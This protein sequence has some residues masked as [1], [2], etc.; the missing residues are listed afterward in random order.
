MAMRREYGETSDE[1]ARREEMQGEKDIPVHVPNIYIGYREP[2][3]YRDPD[4]LHW[5]D[6][7]TCPCEHCHEKR[8]LTGCK[9]IT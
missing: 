3:G 4:N 5:H 8:K 1:F 6:V 7:S 9:R 2:V